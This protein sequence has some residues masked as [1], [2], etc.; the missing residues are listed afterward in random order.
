MVAMA[1]TLV[2][3]LSAFTMFRVNDQTFRDQ[4]LIAGMQQN[5]R[6]VASQIAEELRMGGQGVPVYAAMFD[7]SVQE[8]ATSILD[9]SNASTIRF[10]SGVSNVY[11]RAT[12]PLTY[13]GGSETVSVT[14]AAGFNTAIAGSTTRFVY[15]YGK[16]ASTWTWLRA[17]VSAVNTGANTIT[18]QRTENGTNGT[19]F[20]TAQTI[21]LEEGISY[22][23]NSG[24]ILRGTVTDFTS[25]TAPTF[26][27]SVVGDNFTALAFT[28]TDRNGNAITPNTLANRAAVWRVDVTVTGQT[29]ANLANGT[30]PTYAMTVRSF[31][32]NLGVH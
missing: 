16:T 10:R 31:P 28:Y 23:L 27:E 17:Q 18:L 29:S 26:T 32:R 19:T 30:R 8:A 4:N 11:S 9:G 25:L 20:I 12:S 6:A 15:I 21:S 5:V 2:I 22:R 14:S 1:I 3:G 24:Q 13:G 7:T